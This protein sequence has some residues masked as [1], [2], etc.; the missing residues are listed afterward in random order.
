M[1]NV[2]S[3]NSCSLLRHTMY[4]CISVSPNACKMRA[5]GPKAVIYLTLG[6]AGQG[7]NYWAEVTKSVRIQQSEIDFHF[8]T[9][10]QTLTQ[11]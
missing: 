4:H 7:E 6:V 9:A 11:F 5:Y 1:V 3:R 10:H 2:S 8:E